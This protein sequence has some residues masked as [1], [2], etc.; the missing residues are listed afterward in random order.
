MQRSRR[1]AT[2]ILLA[3]ALAVGACSESGE[4]GGPSIGGT[5][6]AVIGDFELSSA[7]LEAEVEAW[8]TQ[9]EFLRQV[10]QIEDPGAPGRRSVELVTFVI[11]HRVLSERGRQIM[12]QTGAEV[13]QTE[14]DAIL[15]QIDASFLDVNTG[16]PILALYPEEF[17][18][19]LGEDFVRQTRL[20]E[21]DLTTLTLPEVAVN[22][23]Y[24]TA[25]EQTFGFVQILPPEGPRPAPL[26]LLGL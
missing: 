24:G 21:A 4:L 7:D 25:E 20:S 5:N 17:R 26:N 19:S 2:A 3:A 13:V 1:L 6:A 14:V 15:Q 22:P 12:E 9:P 23:R 11:S 16:T 10:L 8:A 18:Q